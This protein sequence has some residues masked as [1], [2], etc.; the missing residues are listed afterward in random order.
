MKKIIL[1][2]FCTL[3]PFYLSA[4]VEIS[5]FDLIGKWSLESYS[6]EF[7]FRPINNPPNITH[8][9]SIEFYS[10]EKM[11]SYAAQIIAKDD[12]QTDGL[13]ERGIEDFFITYGNPLILHL[14]GG[15]RFC[16]RFRIIKY[17]KNEIELATFDGK[18]SLIYK[19]ESEPTNISS[20]FS[21]NKTDDYIFSI[22]GYK[23]E[24]EPVKGFFIKEG[25]KFVSH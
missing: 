5:E 7:N 19:R 8:P 23:I 22:N 12:T 15:S 2:V 1:L 18:G 4:Q 25:K 11:K 3:L 20:T 13:W 24:K 21:N 14:L 16:L 17:N 6:G 10:D 9:D